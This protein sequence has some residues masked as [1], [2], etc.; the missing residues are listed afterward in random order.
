M[1]ISS[2]ELEKKEEEAVEQNV[3]HCCQDV[4]DRVDEAPAPHGYI[5]AHVTPRSGNINKI[6]KYFKEQSYDVTYTCILIMPYYDYLPIDRVH[7][8][9]WK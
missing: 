3:W 9:Q 7:V 8:P 6:Q 1:Q 5:T 4:C 2:T